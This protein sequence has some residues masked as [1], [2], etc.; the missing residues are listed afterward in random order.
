[1]CIKTIIIHW[2]NIHEAIDA[3]YFEEFKNL[4]NHFLITIKITRTSHKTFQLK[5]RGI[6]KNILKRKFICT[7]GYDFLEKMV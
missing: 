3:T 1:M 5:S 6:I 2:S 7:G 4:P